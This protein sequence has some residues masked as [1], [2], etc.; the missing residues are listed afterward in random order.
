MFS[1]IETREEDDG[2]TPFVPNYVQ[3]ETRE[4]AVT[5]SSAVAAE[6]EDAATDTIDS[7][8]DTAEQKTELM[9]PPPQSSHTDADCKHPVAGCYEQLLDSKIIQLE[10]QMNELEEKYWGTKF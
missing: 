9:P 4:E 8:G 10:E 6:E 2:F 3:L 7:D 5:R 1:G